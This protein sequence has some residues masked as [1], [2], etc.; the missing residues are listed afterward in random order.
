MKKFEEQAAKKPELVD[1]EHQNRMNNYV[2]CALEQF[3]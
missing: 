2:Q 3:Q 1:Q